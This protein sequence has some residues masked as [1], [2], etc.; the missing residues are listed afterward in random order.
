MTS[1][2]RERAT[3]NPGVV[4]RPPL[5]VLGTLLLGFALELLWPTYLP[6]GRAHLGL[7]LVPFVPGV[8]LMTA[9]MRR[10]RAAGTPVETWRP[11]EAIA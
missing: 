6:A 1:A 8:A 5:L 7:W 9:A 3:D 11:T 4:M 2:D 10:F